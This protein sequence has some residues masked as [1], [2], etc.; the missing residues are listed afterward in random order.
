MTKQIYL[1]HLQLTRKTAYSKGI[2]VNLRNYFTNTQ[3]N[4]N[5][6]PEP[7]NNSSY[8]LHNSISRKIYTLVFY[9]TLRP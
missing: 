3:T 6:I 8:R 1:K 7:T 4:A 5:E 9:N 2:A